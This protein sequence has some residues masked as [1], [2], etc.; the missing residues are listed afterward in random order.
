MKRILVIIAL[1]LAV[2]LLTGCGTEKA[3]MD[4]SDGGDLAAPAAAEQAEAETPDPQPAEEPAA[5]EPTAEEPAPAAPAVVTLTYEGESASAVPESIC[6]EPDGR[7]AVTVKGQGFAFNKTLPLRNGKIVVPFSA[8]VRMGG[9]TYSWDTASFSDGAI[10]YLFDLS[11]LPEEVILYSIDRRDEQ[12][13]FDAAPFIVA[14]TS[15][16]AQESGSVLSALAGR[17]TGTGRPVGGGDQIDLEVDLHEDGS[18][19]Y[20]FRQGGYTESYPVTVNEGDGSFTADIPA[21]N[22]LRIVSCGGTYQLDGTTLKLHIVTKFASGRSFEY[23][24]EC[25]R[26]D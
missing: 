2:I 9:N 16:P 15:A 24:V 20:Q 7:L 11:E 22:Y 25:E 4:I 5:E 8:D 18:G 14:G 3:S 13:V 19:T 17:W 21:D 10:K 6:F 1:I 12:F 26:A 23:D